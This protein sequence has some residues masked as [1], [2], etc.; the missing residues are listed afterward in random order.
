MKFKKLLLITLTFVMAG[1]LLAACGN[2]TSYISDQTGKEIPVTS[3]DSDTYTFKLPAEQKIEEIEE[4]PSADIREETI[5]EETE[6]T[7]TIVESEA[8]DEEITE[9]HLATEG[10]KTGEP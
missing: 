7:T 10:P 8:T 4:T 1:F 5:P 3:S 2:N 9:E 6:P